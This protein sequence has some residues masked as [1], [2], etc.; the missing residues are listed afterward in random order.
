MRLPGS[1]F[2][3]GFLEQGLDGAL[4]FVFDRYTKGVH[5]SDGFDRIQSKEVS[6]RKTLLHPMEIELAL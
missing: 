1:S 3:Q 4:W 6:H 5:R 2:P